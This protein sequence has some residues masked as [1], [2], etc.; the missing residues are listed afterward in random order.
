MKIVN[1]TFIIVKQLDVD[2]VRSNFGLLR[3]YDGVSRFAEV[4]FTSK[5]SVFQ[6]GDIIS[7]EG[8]I[9]YYPA[10]DFGDNFYYIKESD[11]N[12]KVK[13]NMFFSIY[14]SVYIKTDKYKNQVKDFGN[15]KIE[16]DGEYHQFRA[17]IVVQSGVVFSKPTKATNSYTQE[18]L[19]V[20]INDGDVIYTHHFLTHK[21]NERVINGETY[22]EIR[23]EDCYF[24]I[25]DDEIIMLNEWNLLTPIDDSE[26][27]THIGNIEIRHQKVKDSKKAVVKNASKKLLSQGVSVG[28]VVYFEKDMDYPIH[29]DNEIVYRV[30]TRNIIAKNY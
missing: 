4:H 9:M 25:V 21:D 13:N 8:Q 26:K 15:L 14:E 20:N 3:D 12:S 22:Y 29:I 6:K 19:D 2:Y 30:N 11:I 24:K 1:S 28:D 7:H 5:E 16:V 18:L 10:S 23:Y 27:E 17:D